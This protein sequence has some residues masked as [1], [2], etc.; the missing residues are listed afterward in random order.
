LML[1]GPLN[2]VCANVASLS[3]ESGPAARIISLVTCVLGVSPEF[4]ER[5][6]QGRCHAAQKLNMEWDEKPVVRGGVTKRNEDRFGPTETFG[7]VSKASGD[8]IAVVGSL[9]C[10][11][12]RGV[13]SQPKE[14]PNHG[15]PTM[16]RNPAAT[17]NGAAQRESWAKYAKGDHGEEAPPPDVSR[18][19]SSSQT[20]SRNIC[21]PTS[22][23][24]AQDGPIVHFEKGNIAAFSNIRRCRSPRSNAAGTM[25][26][27]QPKPCPVMA[28]R[29]GQ[30]CCCR[31]FQKQIGCQAA[32]PVSPNYFL[33][34]RGEA[35]PIRPTP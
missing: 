7:D 22:M 34:E 19:G 9:Y 13:G 15:N 29:A 14:C 24:N 5:F 30:T 27:T 16:S 28:R 10:S 11:T 18:H 8:I 32:E 4:L 1:S 23:G 33:P 6:H 17:M 31:L 12:D 2:R 26:T 20:R 35:K 25:N 3:N 21:Q